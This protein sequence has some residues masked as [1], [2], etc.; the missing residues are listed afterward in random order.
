MSTCRGRKNE[1]PAKVTGSK[2]RAK[3]SKFVY[4]PE[5]VWSTTACQVH[6]FHHNLWTIL[7]PD[8]NYSS[9]NWWSS[10][11]RVETL[12]HCCVVFVCQF[13]TCFYAFLRM[14]LH[15]RGPR[16]GFHVRFFH[17]AV[18]QLPHQRSRGL[19]RSFGEAVRR[20]PAVAKSRPASRK[21]RPA[22][23]C[24]CPSERGLDLDG[25]LEGGNAR[26]RR[27]H[28][29]CGGDTPPMTAPGDG[30]EPR[31]LSAM[32]KKGKPHWTLLGLSGELPP[33]SLSTAQAETAGRRSAH[34]PRIEAA[35]Q[36]SV[37]N[38]SGVP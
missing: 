10:R 6:A 34:P 33:R 13:T 3:M 9:L 38:A 26:R 18:S 5:T 8:A 37:F 20:V 19:T 15:V 31:D 12:Y 2:T 16:S 14:S 11:Q 32:T 22:E 1:H 35:A 4:R 28:G 36:G 25:D 21:S 7:R 30:Q 17:L 29:G 24:D 27:G 23:W